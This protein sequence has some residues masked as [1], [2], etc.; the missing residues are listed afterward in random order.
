MKVAR[1]GDKI[2]LS[3]GTCRKE[4]TLSEA[5][6]L[7]KA[8]AA[9]LG[10]KLSNKTPTVYYAIHGNFVYVT[11]IEGRGMRRATIPVKVLEAYIDTLTE[12][13]VGRHRKDIIA[14]KALKRLISDFPELSKFFDDRVF[15]W[16]RF[17]G[18]RNTYYRFFRYPLLILAKNNSIELERSY[19]TV[20]RLPVKIEM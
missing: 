1:R 16:E 3:S 9:Q 18:A 8:L 19:I 20:K 10:Y 15:D 11:V 12:A 6:E 13:G 14:S 5:T 2:F 4:L 17:F 7:L